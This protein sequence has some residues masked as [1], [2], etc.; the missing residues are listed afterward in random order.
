MKNLMSIAKTKSGR[1]T[2]MSIP[3][4]LQYLNDKEL[5]VL[6]ETSGSFKEAK[7]ALR[8]L[9]YRHNTGQLENNIDL[10]YLINIVYS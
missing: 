5:S 2:F 10:D 9:E 3:D 6:I 1:D 7:E 8:I 4:M